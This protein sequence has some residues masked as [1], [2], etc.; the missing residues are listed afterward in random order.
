MGKSENGEIKK[1]NL[2]KT[3]VIGVEDD[4]LPVW[5]KRMGTPIKRT[6]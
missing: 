1:S 5:E 6:N 3:P 4:K 2:T